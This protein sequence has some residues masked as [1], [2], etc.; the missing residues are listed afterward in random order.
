MAGESRFRES[1]LLRHLFKTTVAGF[2]EEGLASGQRM[3]V[4]ASLIE[5]DAKVDANK[6]LSAPKEEWDAGR[7]DVEAAPRAVKEYLD[8]L[9]EAAFGAATPVKPEFTSYSYIA[10][11][12]TAVRKGPAFFAYSENYFIDTDH[13][14]VLDVEATRLIRQAEVGS[15]KTML[16]RLNATFDLHPERLIADTAYGSGPMLGWLVD[17]KIAPHIPVIDKAG[18]LSGRIVLSSK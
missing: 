14:V 3:S 8:T 12:W 6:Q 5:A 13:G 4:D 17:S 7:I 15:S 2:I 9:D 10:S 16:D 1:E 18:H 11:Q